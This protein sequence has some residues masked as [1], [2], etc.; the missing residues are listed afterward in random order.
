MSIKEYKRKRDFKKTPEPISSAKRGKKLIFVIQKH[1]ASHLHYDFRLEVKGVLKS[2]AVPKGPSLN[3]KDKRLAMMVEDHPY[4]YHTFEGVIPEGN[5]GAGI[6]MVWDKGFYY[7][8]DENY[9]FASEAE[10][11]K[12]IEAGKIHFALAG[13]KVKGLFSLVKIKNASKGNPKGNSWLLIKLED[14]FVTDKDILKQDRSVLTDR[15]LNQIAKNAPAPDK[16]VKVQLTNQDKI[17]WPKEGYTKGDLIEYYS[18]IANLILPYLKDRPNSLHRF[19]N[20][21]EEEG[22]YQKNVDATIPNWVPTTQIQHSKDWVRYLMIQD[23]KSLLFA[24][25][26]GCIEIN[27]FNSRIQ[28]LDNPDYL[29]ID[30]DPETTSFKNVIETAQTIHELLE[31]YSIPS[32][33]KTSG[34]TGLHIYIPLGAKY[35]YDIVRPFAQLLVEHVHQQLPKLTSLERKP[36]KRQRKVYLDYLQ[37]NFGQTVAAPYCVRPLPGAP[38]STPLEWKEVKEG[39]DPTSF[40]MKNTLNRLKKKGDLFKGVLGKGIDIA[41]CLKRLE[42]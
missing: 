10:M 7:P 38:V 30:L 4:D 24:I 3:P 35:P 2:W 33:C 37:N 27:P 11:H 16:S 31:N 18:S 36:N 13:E 28:S 26:L 21:I 29:I 6:V 19:P 17:F 25:N 5:Y 32:Y 23:K 8:I 40:T 42:K 20:G 41:K 15:S 22:F 12:G 14:D 34:A 9:N 1:A 39:L